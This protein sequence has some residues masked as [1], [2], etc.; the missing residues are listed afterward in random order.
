MKGQGRVTVG[1]ERE[2]AAELVGKVEGEGGEA[3]RE[4]SFNPSTFRIE[5]REKT[6]YELPHASTRNAP[7]GGT[8]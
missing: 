4:I 5:G 2:V 1:V 6:R 7:G 3:W 8:G